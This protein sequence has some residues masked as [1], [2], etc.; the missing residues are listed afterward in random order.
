MNVYVF[1]QVLRIY[2]ENS[3]SSSFTIIG[4]KLLM[5]TYD[6]DVEREKEKA[7]VASLEKDKKVKPNAAAAA[8]PA[9][10]PP[11]K[12]DSKNIELSALE[13]NLAQINQQGENAENSSSIYGVIMFSVHAR[14]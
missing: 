11:A 5:S 9:A 6:P 10:K 4:K 2:G 3:L 8:T 14:S 12:T 7:D 1:E 13:T